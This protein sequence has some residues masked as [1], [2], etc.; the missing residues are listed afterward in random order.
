MVLGVDLLAFRRVEDDLESLDD[1]GALLAE[2]LQLLGVL[3]ALV[4][5]GVTTLLV[6]GREIRLLAVEGL[7]PVRHRLLERRLVQAGDVG[8][9]L[10]DVDVEGVRDLRVS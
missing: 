5:V 7:A 4:P 9:Q 3:G 6:D 2:L 1:L 10:I 8:P